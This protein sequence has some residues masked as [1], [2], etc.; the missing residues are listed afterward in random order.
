MFSKKRSNRRACKI[1]KWRWLFI[2]NL[3]KFFFIKTVTG[4][5]HLDHVVI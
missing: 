3:L 2:E 5:N 4:L 1:K